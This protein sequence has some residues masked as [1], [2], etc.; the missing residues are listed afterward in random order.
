MYVNKIY[1]LG[2][3]LSMLEIVAKDFKNLV[4]SIKEDIKKTQYRVIENSNKELLE[5]SI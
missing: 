2:R 1:K 4:I 5:L 3:R